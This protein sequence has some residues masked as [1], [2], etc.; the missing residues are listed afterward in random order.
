MPAELYRHIMKNEGRI[1][2]KLGMNSSQRRLLIRWRRVPADE[3]RSRGRYADQCLIEGKYLRIRAP[4]CVHLREPY[5][6]VSE[7]V[8]SLNHTVL[9]SRAVV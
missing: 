8:S 3:R 7:D 5:A 1:Y 9:K 6:S 4:I 2:R